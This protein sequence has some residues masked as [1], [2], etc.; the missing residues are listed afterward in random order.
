MNLE[1][2][3]N[4]EDIFAIL[5]SNGLGSSSL[6]EKH[7]WLMKEMG[8]LAIKYWY[9][10]T[11]EEKWENMLCTIL[12]KDRFWIKSKFA[13]IQHNMASKVTFKEWLQTRFNSEESY[14]DWLEFMGDNI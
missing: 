10:A 2:V 12:E 6:E 9:G 14:K 7:N 5:E 4:C 11:D 13:N 3:R 1:E 8:V